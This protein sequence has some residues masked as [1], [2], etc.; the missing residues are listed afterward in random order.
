MDTSAKG[1]PVAVYNPLAIEREDPVEAIVPFTGEAPRSIVA[2]DP[3]GQPVPTQILDRQDRTLRV[4]F[5]AKVPSVGYAVYD[6]RPGAGEPAKSSLTVSANSLENTRYR[7]SLNAAGD[8]ASV[9]D[10]SLNREMLSA[11]TSLSFHTENP[12]AYPA[13]NMNYED[14]LLPAKAVVGGPAKIRVLEDGPARVALEVERHGENSTFVQEI[15]LAA[16]G[17]ADRLEVVNRIDWRTLGVSLRAAFPLAATN[18]EATFDDKA[19]VIRRGT[20]DPKH[21]ELAQQQWMDLTDKDGAFGV[22]ILNDCKYGSDKPDD[23]TLRTTMIHT[24]G[25]RDRFR[26]QATQDIGRHEIGL[27]F[28]AHRGSW[29]EGRTA[30]QAARFNQPLRAFLPAAHPGAL[31]RT[32]SLVSL[33]NDQ[34]QIAAVKQAED[35]NEIVV[36]LKELTGKPAGNLSVRFAAPVTAAREIDAQERPVGNATVKDG[37]LACDIKAFGLR[38]FAVKLAP[39]AAPAPPVASQPVALVYDT[40]VVSSRANR[41]DGA[42]TADGAAYPAEMFPRKVTRAGVDFQLGATTDGAKNAVTAHG[43]TLNLPAGSFN[44][45]HLLAAGDGDA[46]G[47]IKIG[48]ASQPFAVPNWTG[49]IGQWDNR[50]WSPADTDVEHQGAPVGLAPGYIKR[51][52]VAWFATHHNTPQGDAFYEYSYLFQLSYDLPAGAT[53]VTLPDN[54]KIRVFAASVSREAAPAPAAAPLYD[55][56]ADHQPGGA[57]VIVQAGQSYSDATPI[58]LLPPLYH[59]PND[60]HYTLDGTDPTAASPVYDGPFTVADTVNI[61]ARQIDAERTTRRDHARHGQRPRHHRARRWSMCAP[62]RPTN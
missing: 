48:G 3:Q 29:E 9:F 55:T 41:N 18:A 39:P 35:S 43:Q 6:L 1:T 47:Q 52:P 34:V 13:W 50:L 17:A 21:F 45:I 23:H 5:L 7:V 11:P 37:A 33:N 62:T 56:L 16:G 27:A 49:Y 22:S 38:A 44:R 59:R 53:S 19:G 20:N 54:P 36:R 24:P 60:L 40:D 28:V 8:I 25:V 12:F 2:Y 4:L 10:K 31:G 15:R 46:S 14:R 57:P 26:D 51:T 58:T 42:M 30:W 61:A 32:F